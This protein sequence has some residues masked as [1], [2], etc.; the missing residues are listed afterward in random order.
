MEEFDE[1]W[2][3]LN[4]DDMERRFDEKMAKIGLEHNAT[5]MAILEI[6]VL[7]ELTTCDDFFRIRARVLAEIDQNEAEE[8]DES[9]RERDALE[10]EDRQENP[11]YWR[12][13]D[14]MREKIKKFI[15]DHGL[16]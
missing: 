11:E 14:S 5:E 16:E 8:K 1:V 15:K 10:Q 13:V 9:K 12:E 7:K 6:L 3:R 4:L 2:V